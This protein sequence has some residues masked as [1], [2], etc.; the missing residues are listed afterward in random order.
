MRRLL[1]V[2]V[3]AALA[4]APVALHGQAAL[5]QTGQQRQTTP[6]EASD[7]NRRVLMVGIG[8]IVGVIALNFAL[9]GAGPYVATAGTQVAQAGATIG[10][11]WS[12]V[13]GGI[14]ALAGA[15]PVAVEAAAPAA[16]ASVA[17]AAAAPAAAVA[18]AP[19]ASALVADPASGLAIISG[20]GGAMIG[21]YIYK[22]FGG[23]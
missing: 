23:A 15:A 2:L 11:A 6:Y 18:A 10:W 19:A 8:M 20:I 3:V 17:A 14:A 13:S 9:E 5:A 4:A 21:H 1:I 22:L 12:K 16:A 7:W